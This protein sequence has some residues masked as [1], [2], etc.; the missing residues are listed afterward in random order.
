MGDFN[1]TAL[2]TA[3]HKGNVKVARALINKGAYVNDRTLIGGSALDYAKRQNNA[4]MVKILNRCGRN[5]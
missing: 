4:E 5:R 2:M 3:S 1:I